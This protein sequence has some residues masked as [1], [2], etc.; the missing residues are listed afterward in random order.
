MLKADVVIIG[1]G[2]VGCAIA[3]ELS[4]FKLDVMVVDK[5]E[6]V[7]GDASKS[8]SAIIHTGYDAAPGTLE[9]ELVV[10]ANPM[11]D[12]ITA[13]LNVPFK[14]VGAILPAISDEQYDLLP[15]L[16]KKAF[17]N[18]VYDVEFKTR[19]DLLQME[20]NL[21]PNVRAGLYIPR[22]S[23]I[24]PF[25]YV[26]ALAE[27]ALQNGVRFLMNSRVTAIRTDG[28]HIESVVAGSHE[29][30]TEY[31]INAAG[32]YC[33]DMDA[34]L[35]KSEFFVNPRK[36]QFFVLD[37][38]TACRVNHIVLPIPTKQT[39]GKLVSPTIHGNM[40]AGPTAEDLTDKSDTSTTM[41]GLDSIEA[42]V[43]NLV[44]GLRLSDIITLY[45]GLR[46]RRNPDGLHVRTYDDVHGYV[47]LSG[48]RSTGLT[49][50]LSLGKYV[51]QLL[52]D[53]GLK[54]PR[55]DHFVPH[56]AGI[57]RF[58]DEAPQAQAALLQKDPRYGRI[59][60]R[61]EKVTEGDIVAAIHRPIPALSLDALK[62]RLQ[63]GM[64][65][66]QGGF[67]GPR[68]IE[69]LSRERGI[70]PTEVTKM[71]GGSFMIVGKVR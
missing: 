44:P 21:N 43:R 12:R 4:A 33:D 61:C 66:C 13:D 17:Q 23:I 55:S 35:G 7:G 11:F 65:R 69:I 2:A 63:A 47:S 48:V 37:K 29:I 6:D 62:R 28:G 20:P 41:A 42:D 36:G 14:R 40:L 58:C 22:E 1:A 34:M 45:A 52:E 39:K 32:L 16:I 27:N 3:R 38:Q 30:K 67:C 10:A 8:N 9:S 5:N 54:A 56:G 68:L 49:A 59:V 70:P 71:G 25:L 64:G 53:M 46:P 51:L 15:A 60:C 57:R 24:D 26:I 50:S 18:R 31:V 19:A